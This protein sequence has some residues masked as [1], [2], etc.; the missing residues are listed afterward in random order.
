M[1]YC[2][3]NLTNY[4]LGI[5]VRD[6]KEK[7]MDISSFSGHLALVNKINV[8]KKTRCSIYIYFTFYSGALE[9]CHF[10]CMGLDT[11]LVHWISNVSLHTETCYFFD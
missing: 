4:I 5:A 9:L 1:S 2:N 10:K 8:V 7:I 6:R 11:K 3:S